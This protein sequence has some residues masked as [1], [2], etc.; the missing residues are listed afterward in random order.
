MSLRVRRT[1]MLALAYFAAGA[2]ALAFAI[3]PGYAVVAWPSA[4][5]A[6]AALWLWGAE[7]WPGVWLGS[8]A[9]NAAGAWLRG[10]SG[11]APVFLAAWIGVGATVQALAAAALARRATGGREPLSEERHLFR[12]MMAAGPLAG[13]VA[14]VWGTAGMLWFGQIAPH[15]A[16]Y[17]WATWWVGDAIGV[18][19]A[20]P[21]IFLWS[22]RGPTGSKKGKATATAIMSATLIV[23]FGIHSY[24]LKSGSRQALAGADQRLNGAAMSLSARLNSSFDAVHETAAL[25]ES[26]PRIGRPEFSTFARSILH[27]HPELLSL[28]WRPRPSGAA[29]YQEPADAPRRPGSVVLRTE[30]RPYGSSG[31]SGSVEGVL[32]VDQAARGL[33]DSED[34]TEFLV[35]PVTIGVGA[36]AARSVRIVAAAGRRWRLAARSGPETPPSGG[37]AQRW[38]VLGRV[39]ILMY[40]ASWIALTLYG[41]AERISTLVQFKTTELREQERR[42]MRAQRMESVG[43]LAGGVAHEFNN[44]LMAA[45]G[46][47]QIVRASL[48]A[49]H[50][51]TPDVDSIIAALRRAGNL[52]AQLL[53]YSRRREA[54]MRPTDLDALVAGMGKMLG[55]ALGRR[56]ALELRTGGAPAWI[57]ADAGQVEQ[58]LLNLCFNARDAVAGK[59]TIRVNTRSETLEDGMDNAILP[60]ASGRYWVLEVADDGPG[61]S[62]A[63]RARLTEPFFTTKPFGEGTG[64][65][66]AVV[67]GIV[68]QHGGGLDIATAPEKGALVSVYWPACPPP[69][70]ATVPAGAAIV[71]RGSE[72]ILIV[73]DEPLVRST[74]E[75]L[76]RGFGYET[77][78]ASGGMEGVRALSAVL[79]IRA[80]VLDLVMPGMDGLETYDRMKALRPELKV[81]FLSGFAPQELTQEIRRRGAPFL[82]KPAEPAALARALRATLDGGAA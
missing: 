60:V 19:F 78:S 41:R 58:V 54:Q 34:S 20:A 57:M 35:S 44:I 30:A 42:V 56:V 28:A 79:D 13:L 76:L 59:G 82:G 68:R 1:L 81:L 40:L 77:L 2:G 55:A 48:G 49:E 4:G 22:G 67:S 47:A 12:F 66:L 37:D 38:L 71:P 74:L 26:V 73:D 75:R 17:T 27:A 6:V 14:S 16:L 51:S 61:V 62:P 64:L 9:A 63:V 8:F 7:L 80:V 25:I 69:D 18:V 52:V 10:A 39:M 5:I 70:P 11:A 46:L 24:T 15:Q 65:G 33:S 53:T 23:V 36:D 31:H 43:R 72:K 21:L 3:A 50:P 32:D 45:S 29:L